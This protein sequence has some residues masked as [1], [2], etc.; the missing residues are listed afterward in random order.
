MDER[1]GPKTPPSRIK[2]SRIKRS[3]IRLIDRA[4]AG[5]VDRKKWDQ[6][7]QRTGTN[8]SLDDW[9]DDQVAVLACLT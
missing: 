3:R 1:S 4:A 2:R 8:E 9:L 7:N 5:D 6:I